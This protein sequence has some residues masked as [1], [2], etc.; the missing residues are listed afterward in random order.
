MNFVMI[1]GTD[2]ELFAPSIE[3]D[4]TLRLFPAVYFI[5]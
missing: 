4:A 1:E 5:L 2:G 3:N